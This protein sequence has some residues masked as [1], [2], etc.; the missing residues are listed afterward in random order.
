MSRP[1]PPFS[2]RLKWSIVFQWIYA[3]ELASSPWPSPCTFSGKVTTEHSTLSCL[4]CSEL[5]PCFAANASEAIELGATTKTAARRT[6]LSFFHCALGR[7]A[8]VGQSKLTETDTLPERENARSPDPITEFAF[9]P[10]GAIRHSRMVYRHHHR[11]NTP[12]CPSTTI[13]SPFNVNITIIKRRIQKLYLMLDVCTFAY[14]STS[15]SISAGCIQSTFPCQNSSFMICLRPNSSRH[16]D[17][18]L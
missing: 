5:F 17:T 8:V 1:C 9:S 13:L 4:I 3:I 11:R 2:C 6:S 12:I 14:I 18:I 16:F 10:L 7:L 15:L